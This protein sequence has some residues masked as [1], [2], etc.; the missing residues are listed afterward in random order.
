MKYLKYRT[1][2]LNE[3]FDAKSLSKTMGWLSKSGLKPGDFLKDLKQLC[4]SN[5]ITLS[6]IEDSFFKVNVRRKE[7]LSQKPEEVYNPTGWGYVKFWFSAKE[8]YT[9]YTITSKNEVKKTNSRN[10][11]QNRPFDEND[12]ENV[13]K[14]GYEKGE[15]KTV[16]D[17]SKLKTGDLAF[18][19][20]N[21]Q[22]KV[23]RIFVSHSSRGD[24]RSIYFIGDSLTG[25]MPDDYSWYDE[26]GNNLG[27]KF[28]SSEPFYGNIFTKL[29][30]FN[31]Y[32]IGG[33]FIANENFEKSTD[34]DDLHLYNKSDEPIHV[35][36]SSSKEDEGVDFLSFN[37]ANQKGDSYLY[38]IDSSS[39]DYKVKKS[40]GYSIDKE[41]L[42][43][44]DFAIIFYLDDFLAHYEDSL[45]SIRTG[46]KDARKD[47]TALMNDEEIKRQNFA[48]RINYLVDKYEL[49]EDI[50]HI[51][52]LK[53]T[54]IK[55]LRDEWSLFTIFNN[56][57]TSIISLMYEFIQISETNNQ[58]MKQKLEHIKI[59]YKDLL[60]NNLRRVE[61]YKM[62]YNNILEN[63]RSE[64]KE[65]IEEVK[66]LS[67]KLIDKVR[68]KELLSLY[69]AS[70]LFERLRN[71]RSPSNEYIKLP[72]NAAECLNEFQYI[73]DSL[74]FANAIS[75]I[76]IV[77]RALSHIERQID[78]L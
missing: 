30:D 26:N 59:E 71:M 75:D 50:N 8:G 54:I 64:A 43:N 51:T 2:F 63:G 65:F 28:E 78:Q 35:Y 58:Y 15:L 76:P 34:H 14:L 36:G 77:K 1:Q 7:A 20:I 29:C 41:S 40:R 38:R 53:S 6:N 47:A 46:R 11:N 67:K 70:I 9:G 39:R 42:D 17:Y 66:R 19:K 24:L 18:I 23:G 4:E 31:L 37:L 12:I 44:S 10:S 49:S 61:K 60:N 73:D 52:N 3:A 22:L 45:K 69:D 57:D 68:S 56:L 48:K 5:D 16:K 13:I 55:I 32:R 33:W 74:H 27:R 72:Y 25:S 62:S 21:D